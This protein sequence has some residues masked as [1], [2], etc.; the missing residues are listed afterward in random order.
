M[1]R[2]HEIE[3]SIID[4]LQQSLKA[5]GLISSVLGEVTLRGRTK[6]SISFTVNGLMGQRQNFIIKIQEN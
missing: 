5:G 2:A 4:T 3:Q 6:R 1:S